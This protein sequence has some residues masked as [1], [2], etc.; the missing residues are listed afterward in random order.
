MAKLPYETII[1]NSYGEGK[2]FEEISR[3]I[4]A[5]YGDARETSAKEMQELINEQIVGNFDLQQQWFQNL[6]DFDQNEVTNG[7]NAL[8]PV[9]A[10]KAKQF[11]KG[12]NSRVKSAYAGLDLDHNDITYVNSRL[13]LTINLLNGAIRAGNDLQYGDEY[14]EQPDVSTM[15]ILTGG[16]SRKTMGGRPGMSGYGGTP[17]ENMTKARDRMRKVLA[18]SERLEQNFADPNKVS[19]R[20]IDAVVNELEQEGTIVLDKEKYVDAME[21]RAEATFRMET[22]HYNQDVKGAEQRKM[23]QFR[24]AIESQ[25]RIIDAKVQK[26]F[27]KILDSTMQ[28]EG[29]EPLD[30]ALLEQLTAR[31]L[32]RKHKKVR[33]DKKIT[34]RIKTRKLRTKKQRE[35]ADRDAKA[36]QA[37]RKLQAAVQLKLTQ[38]EGRRR[39]PK[40]QRML[41]AERIRIN[42]QLAKAVKDNMGRPRLE[43]KSGRFAESVKLETLHVGQK[44]V[45]GQYSYQYEPYSTFENSSRWSEHYNPKPL[46][47][48]SIRE[49]AT[50]QMAAKFTLRKL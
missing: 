11:L 47:T 35:K 42:S 50:K 14:T 8:G 12:M 24:R 7:I 13:A 5:S 33:S 40:A 31:G 2:K 19:M 27:E 10:E 26:E 3:K 1:K 36:A 28:I 16:A 30:R 23:G 39:D 38:N 29:S 4:I 48:Q 6:S 37:E 32:K 18:V 46:I 44:T 20:T 9:N 34:K 15:A 22:S 43:N 45:I 25:N 21:G 41:N 49:L 17:M